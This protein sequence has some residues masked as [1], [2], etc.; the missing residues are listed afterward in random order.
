MSGALPS[1][2]PG[3]G[4][5]LLTR[6]MAC[7]GDGGRVRRAREGHGLWGR[8]LSPPSTQ[9]PPGCQLPGSPGKLGAAV[10]LPPAPPAPQGEACRP[11]VPWT[12]WD[13]GDQVPLGFGTSPELCYGCG[14][15]WWAAQPA[16]QLWAERRC[17][18]RG[19]DAGPGHGGPPARSSWGWCPRQGA[20]MPTTIA[21]PAS[22]LQCL[23]PAHPKFPCNQQA[24]VRRK[25]KQE[26]GEERWALVAPD[27]LPLP[28]CRAGCPRG[29]LL[30][31]QRPT[32]A[33]ALLAAACVSETPPLPIAP[34][35][36]PARSWGQRAAPGLGGVG[37]VARDPIPSA[38]TES[39]EISA[40]LE[41]ASG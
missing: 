15:L 17:G 12:G 9:R 36:L 40:W 27:G 25:E 21:L 26:N 10:D 41:P 4:A 13:D 19:P 6:F 23:L 32:V 2:P 30:S 31:L 24:A 20:A 8:V 5:V 33:F 35:P 14:E 37:Q 34:Q 3:R 7:G 39:P 22:I 29:L 16:G 28:H 11:G 1:T 38:W 18:L